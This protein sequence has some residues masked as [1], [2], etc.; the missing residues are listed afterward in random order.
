MLLRNQ[1]GASPT[2]VQRHSK[3]YGTH[4][5]KYPARCHCCEVILLATEETHCLRC[6]GQMHLTGGGHEC[7][8]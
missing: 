8:H 1:K 7:T 4:Y 6:R 2:K 5:T 3:Y